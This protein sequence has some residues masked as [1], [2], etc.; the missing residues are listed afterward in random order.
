MESVESL[1]ET[2]SKFLTNT[3]DY[4]IIKTIGRGGYGKVD[5][6]IH[7]KTGKKVAIK[8]L[9]LSELEGRQLKLYS[10][11]VQILSKLKSPFLLH[12]D[13]FT[14]THPYC[15][16]TDF[17]EKGSLF[18]A[19]HHKSGAPK[20]TPTNKTII[21]MGIAYGMKDLHKMDIIHRDLKSLNILL[22][23]NI[24][25][26][27]CDFGISRFKKQDGSALTLQIGT[28]HWMAPELY[29]PKGYN[30]KVDVFAYGV[31]L[32]EILTE[33]TPFKGRTAMQIMTAICQKGERPLFPGDT[34]Q[35]LIDLINLCWYQTPE[36]RPTFAQI[37]KLF[38]EKKVMYSGTNTEEIDKFIAYIKKEEKKLKSSELPRIV[39]ASNEEEKPKMS[40]NELLEG[41]SSFL[42]NNYASTLSDILKQLT[43]D[44]YE[45]YFRNLYDALD[46][47]P[48]SKIINMLI[49]NCAS[50]V[51]RDEK[52]KRAFNE[53][54]VF[55]KIYPPSEETVKEFCSL[56]QFIDPT[57][58]NEDILREVAA[59]FATKEPVSI[60]ELF[61]RVLVNEERQH[62]IEQYINILFT[63]LP[64]MIKKDA[65]TK[66]ISNI[67]VIFNAK[68]MKQLQPRLNFFVQNILS[69]DNFEQVRVL[70]SGLHM[71]TAASPEDEIIKLHIQNVLLQDSVLEYLLNVDATKYSLSKEADLLVV[72]LCKEKKKAVLALSNIVINATTAK[73]TISHF[74]S[75]VANCDPIDVLQIVSSI[76]GANQNL[77]EEIMKHQKS[78]EM[79]TSVIKYTKIPSFATIAF[80]FST[81]KFTDEIIERFN[82]CN[83]VNLLIQKAFDDGSDSSLFSMMTIIDILSDTSI[84]LQ[85]SSFDKYSQKLL[86]NEKTKPLASLYIS[87]RKQ[88]N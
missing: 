17:I 10:R 62:I 74:G 68:R 41:M 50:V 14:T 20:L 45:D 35:C 87:K 33:A 82:Q 31:I 84:K 16:I 21:A 40:I 11:E 29:D 32:W 8:E 71:T 23:D 7:Q 6:G 88:N 37:Y 66:V 19:L 52:A 15:I 30:N 43:E 63:T 36:E 75:L 2:L 27:I 24:Y 44:K 4:K 79:F 70:Y 39:K 38:A 57:L 55:N 9:F 47:E 69:S 49:E 5:V 76:A 3:N 34:P 58:I 77:T 78:A 48:P 60:S 61:V 12:L 80:I 83:F 86:E 64:S 42:N 56:M 46:F 54:N 25:P 72:N 51:C 13:G 81:T 59:K 26:K 85:D 18:D 65:I 67:D 53:S 28:P 22:D 1:Q 73:N